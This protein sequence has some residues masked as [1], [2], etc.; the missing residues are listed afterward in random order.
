MHSTDHTPGK[1]WGKLH[2]DKRNWPE[3]NEQLVVRGEFYL[4][5]SFID[6]WYSELKKANESKRGG[7]QFKFPESFIGWLVTW[8]QLV[9]YRGLEGIARKLCQFGLIPKYPD[10][11]T[12]FT[13]IHDLVP[14]ISMPSFSE[15]EVGTDGSG[16]KTNNAGEYRIFKYGDRDAKRK[17][18]LVV[19]ITADVHRKKLLCVEVHIEGKGHT[20]ASIAMQHLSTLKERGI[21][22]KK[23]YGDGAFDQSLLFDKLHFM[24]IK[25]VVKMRKNAS[26]DRYRGS[27]YRRREVREYKEMGYKRWASLNNYGM[28]WPGTEGIFSAVKRKYGENTVSRSTDG[29]IAEGYQRFWAYDEIREYGEKHISNQMK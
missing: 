6:D 22:V 25:P 15:A 11:S 21:K 28:R 18:H 12:I 1:K 14:D 7:G 23:F 24:K 26:A 2:V 3:Y 5:L 4:D 8:K 16:L 13:R 29:L 27:K 17:K 10:F 19:V 9:V 20:E